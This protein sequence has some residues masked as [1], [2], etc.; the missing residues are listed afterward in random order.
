MS[1]AG[2]I[3]SMLSLLTWALPASDD[4]TPEAWL[5]K[6]A[7]FQRG[8]T[9]LAGPPGS[10]HGR[11]Y[12]EAVKPEGG[13]ISLEVERRWTRSPERI[14]T[15]R[16]DSILD[17]DT[18][19][20]FDGRLA[21]F[22][23]HSSGDVLLYTDDPEAFE[24]DIA[25]IHDDLR[26]TSLLL[27]ASLIDVL[28]PGLRDLRVLTAGQPTTLP[29][30]DN[31]RHP[32]VVLGALT[33]DHFFGPDP[34]APPP[35]RGAT[36]PRVR[37]E[38]ALD[39]ASGAVRRVRLAT[40]DRSEPLAVELRVALHDITVDGLQMPA[41]IE[42]VEGGRS[43]L[44]MG[45]IPDADGRLIYRLDPGFDDALFS[46]PGNE[47]SAEPGADAVAEEADDDSSSSDG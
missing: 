2:L 39:R 7:Q 12:V 21:W 24:A 1:Y 34:S 6:A 45:V 26:L 37:V 23:D 19:V 32:V 10:F 17:S 43:A 27:E 11:F 5:D 15:R 9:P 38:L 29:D 35:S 13:K 44:Q 14:L 42:L 8:D 20:G 36:A 31:R 28:R 46:P 41:S 33:D 4:P 3:A 25:L 47:L 30:I 22:V 16:Q 18:S 40:L